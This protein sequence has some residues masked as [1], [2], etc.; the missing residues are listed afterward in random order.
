M[1]LGEIWGMLQTACTGI[2]FDADGKLKAG[3]PKVE[4]YNLPNQVISCI[5][6]WMT[7]RII[8]GGTSTTEESPGD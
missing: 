6:I 4:G 7:T 5:K 3:I 2:D 1:E 8:N